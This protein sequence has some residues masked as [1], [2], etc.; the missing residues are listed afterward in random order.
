M[1]ESLIN[2][3]KFAMP[4]YVDTMENVFEQT[5]AAWPLRAFIIDNERIVFMLEPKDPGYYDLSDLHSELRR[6]FA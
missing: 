5:Y 3:Y 1:G 2:E 4:L 6:R